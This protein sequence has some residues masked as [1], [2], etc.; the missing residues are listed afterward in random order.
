MRMLYIFQNMIFKMLFVF[1]SL[2]I[3]LIC[4]YVNAYTCVSKLDS[5]FVASDHE[6][7]VDVLMW[8]NV[9]K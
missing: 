5:R 7:I 1:Y 9:N 3:A 4:L 2:L 6:I 8:C